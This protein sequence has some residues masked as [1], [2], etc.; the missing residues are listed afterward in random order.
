MNMKGGCGKTT[1]ATGLAAYYA[2]QGIK[3]CLTDYDP[4]SSSI[5]WLNRRDIDGASIHGIDASSNNKGRTMAWQRQPPLGTE[6][7]IIDTPAGIGLEQLRKVLSHC[8]TILIPLM[9]S[10]IDMRA[11]ARFIEILLI[12]GK[13]KEK[14][15]NI[16]IIA[17]RTHPETSEYYPIKKFLSRLDIPLIATLHDMQSYI[18]ASDNG[19]G[20]HEIYNEQAIS[21]HSQWNELVEWLE[22]KKGK[23]KKPVKFQY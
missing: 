5:N 22:Q 3:T 21:E 18:D 15:I 4:Q 7:S 13:V 23:S 20:I 9:P 2:N 12:Q 19:M 16:G 14:G 10:K 17:N 1:I 6:I 11:T 8:D